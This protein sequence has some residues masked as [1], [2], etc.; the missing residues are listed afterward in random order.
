MRELLLAGLLIA[1]GLAISSGD[2]APD[3]APHL[4]EAVGAVHAGR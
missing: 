1:L 4:T 2:E 3:S